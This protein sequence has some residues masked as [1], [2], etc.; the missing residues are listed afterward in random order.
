MNAHV[1]HLI[2]AV[3]VVGIVLIVT[4]KVIASSDQQAHDRV[5]LAQKQLDNDKSA[6][7]AAETQAQTDKNAFN[8]LKTQLDSQN[9][10]LKAQIAGLAASLRAQ[11]DKDRALPPNELADRHI[12]LIGGVP[13]DVIPASN[14]ILMTVPAAR[15]TVVMLE[16]V[17]SDRQTILRQVDIINNS[18]S[19]LLSAQTAL[20]SSE[21]ALNACKSTQVSADLACKAQIAEEK[22][23]ARKRNVVVAILGA[24]FGFLVRSKI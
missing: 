22:A 1:K 7:K 21:S 13:G 17:E 14:G 20:T 3:F 2:I 4:W 9:A 10:S 18:T 24:V 19:E 11:Q 5:I 15:S 23:K 8:L 16:E 6:Q 12:A